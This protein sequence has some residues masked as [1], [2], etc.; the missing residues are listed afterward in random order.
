MREIIKKLFHILTPAERG[1]MYL[2]FALMTLTALVEVAGVA[3]I[4]P[5]LS[6]VTDPSSIHTN[7]F[8]SFLYS[9]FN[10]RSENSFLIFTG[11]MVLA[12]LIVGN[13]LKSLNMWGINRFTGGQNFRISKRL[14][15]GY[16]SRP[17]LFFLNKN[18]SELG[19]NIL[20]EV[21]Q[22]VNGV[23]YP[24]MH[25]AARSIVS[26]FIFALLFITDPLLAAIVL[27]VLSAAYLV[28]YRFIKSRVTDIGRRR[29]ETNTTRFRVVSE[30]F[31]GIKELKLMGCEEVFLS[32]FS[33]P[34]SEFEKYQ[35]CFK[36]ISAVPQYL[37]ELVAFGGVMIIV[38]YLII[39]GRGLGTAIPVIGLY[40]FATHRLMPSLQTVFRQ[41]TTI[42]FNARAV[43]ILYRDLESYRRGKGCSAPLKKDIKPLPLKNELRL[44]NIRFTYPGAGEPV[45]KNLN[46]TIKAS[47]SIA[48]A[49]ETGAGKTTAADIILGLL[50]PSNGK[51]LA[52]GTEIT[53]ENL[54][55]WQRNLGYI[56][57]EIYLQDDT[58]ASNVAFGVQPNEIDMKRIEESLKIANLYRFVM[59]ELPDAQHTLIGERGVR[60]SGG[61]RQ[62]IGIARALYHD[63]EILVMD[64][65]TSALDGVTEA[66]VFEAINNISK[67]KTLIMIAH[68]LTTV[69]GCDRVYLMEKGNIT[70][71]GTYGELM[72]NNQTFRRM[73]KAD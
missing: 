36:T 50:R 19:K 21:Q 49:G 44:E 66:A 30:A 28:V 54:A 20:S 43:N 23:M 4:M 14:L 42:R 55:R 56:P 22:V 70:D 48:F 40:A 45:I 67:A 31:G 53:D 3:S 8:L 2:L 33:R 17:Y 57:Q 68:R 58:V 37:M 63:P 1:K 60:L 64:E 25:I 26:V 52:D 65:A 34:A 15:A 13:F 29:F 39:S 59:E 51:I 46:L 73:A 11:V 6:V 18:T 41:V 24:L 32:R 61:Q 10:F 62:R 12:V 35:A 72:K 5:F 47:S 71:S 9:A 69:K 16:I 38:L 7:R 27:A